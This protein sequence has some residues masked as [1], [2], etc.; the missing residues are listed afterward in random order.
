MQ[1][2]SSIKSA[3]AA[4]AVTATGLW[5]CLSAGYY[6]NRSLYLPAALWLAAA[7]LFLLPQRE[8]GTLRIS[9]LAVGPGILA[10]LYA[11]HAMRLAGAP[12]SMQATLEALLRW[13]WLAAAAAALHLAA[14]Y[15]AGRRLL[16]A[17]WS[18]MGL[19]LAATALAALYGLLP[20]RFAVLRTAD[21]GI[22]A[23]GARLGGL[24]QYP[25]A[26]GAIMAAFLLPQQLS[27]ARLSAAGARPRRLLA[28]AAPALPYSLCL[29]LS[30]SRAAWLAC[31]AVWLLA[32]LRAHPQVRL[33]LLPLSGFPLAGAIALCRRLIPAQLAPAPLPGLLELAAVWAA[34]LAAAL[35]TSQLLVSQLLTPQLLMPNRLTVKRLTIQRLTMQQLILKQHTVKRHAVK[36]HTV[37]QLAVQQFTAKLPLAKRKA[38]AGLPRPQPV[39]LS[40]R[41]ASPVACV[42]A[43]VCAAVA[44]IAASLLP[45]GEQVRPVSA[46]IRTDL[47]TLDARWL[48]YRDGWRLFLQAPWL[49]QGGETWRLAYRSVQS[50]P[51][52]GAVMHSGWLDMLLNLGFLGAAVLVCWAGLL[53]Y[54]LL[55][56]RSLWFYPFLVLLVHF[57]VDLDGAYGLFWLLLLWAAA[58]GNPE[59]SHQLH[60]KAR[61]NFALLRTKGQQNS[62]PLCP[63]EQQNPGQ[64]QLRTAAQENP[65]LL[66]LPMQ[67]LSLKRLP[68]QRSSVSRLPIQRLTSSR[69]TLLKSRLIRRCLP[70]QSQSFSCLSL[71][72]RPI[73]KTTGYVRRLLPGIPAAGLAAALLAL[74]CLSLRLLLAEKTFQAAAPQANT[75]QA[76][77]LQATALEVGNPHPP[78]AFSRLTAALTA[79]QAAKLN[80]AYVLAP[81]RQDV[82]AALAD[83]QRSEQAKVD[84][85]RQGLRYNPKSAELHSRLAAA[86]AAEGKAEAVELWKTAVRL[87]P[88][89]A[90]LQ[91]QALRSL[92]NLAGLQ[93]AKGE[94][95]LA[96]QTASAGAALFRRYQQLYVGTEHSYPR[97]N[98]RDFRVTLAAR[99]LSEKLK[100]YQAEQ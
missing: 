53:G 13:S 41:Q 52:V 93:S 15:P 72:R 92:T 20:L 82:L 66:C 48:M 8:K 45:L 99:R 40:K 84:L 77:A 90:A 85:L 61:R 23:F 54:G 18:L 5:G 49:G 60:L 63:N 42:W 27:A 55:R 32:L 73:I 86:S 65:N 7:A 11:M 95:R 44:A 12:L 79:A 17:G 36:Q 83:R 14:A 51:Y 19:L 71:P 75:F 87:D 2:P 24:L 64:L 10:A 78:A 16:R 38:A 22:A 69:R 94:P 3:A 57:A 59:T 58:L 43:A 33:R 6:F 9:L 88:Y 26:F 29:L 21:S 76:I 31:A 74:S 25:N 89:N 56:N 34:A 91:T 39:P 4:A 62:E 67:R 30:E 100:N 35:L 47:S 96:K 46:G 1:M 97:H 80:S 98:D 50:A 70:L 81:W 37:K 28:A 68:L